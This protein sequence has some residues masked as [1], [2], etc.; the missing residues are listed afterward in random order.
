M[1]TLALVLMLPEQLMQKAQKSVHGLSEVKGQRIV[2]T[3]FEECPN[4]SA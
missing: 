4:R 3:L 2:T 1:I